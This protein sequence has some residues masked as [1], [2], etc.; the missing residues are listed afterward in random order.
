MPGQQLTRE[1][2]HSTEHGGTRGDAPLG[3]WSWHWI[4]VDDGHRRDLGRALGNGIHDRLRFGP[5]CPEL[6]IHLRRFPVVVERQRVRW[7]LVC[8]GPCMHRCRVDVQPERAPSDANSG[9]IAKERIGDRRPGSERA[10]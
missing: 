3:S 8:E 4:Q 10:E 2:S 7:R 5:A 6:A 9:R 1:R